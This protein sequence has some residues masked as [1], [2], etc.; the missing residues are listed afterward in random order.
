MKVGVQ[1]QNTRLA[2]A[3]I[4]K[5]RAR[6]R[7]KSQIMQQMLEEAYT[8]TIERS[9]SGS[10]LSEGEHH[11]IPM[12]LR[13]GM[14]TALDGQKCRQCRP[15]QILEKRIPST[16]KAVLDVESFYSVESEGKA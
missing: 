7:T 6:Y 14:R 11:D 2:L 1:P 16:D 13:R 12:D 5:A 8:H 10:I 9:S 4:D 15:T 3:V